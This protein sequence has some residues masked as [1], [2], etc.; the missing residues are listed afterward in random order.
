MSNEFK[1]A[2]WLLNLALEIKNAKSI[3]ITN[4][5]KS[6]GSQD[7]KSLQYQDSQVEII[8]HKKYQ[9]QEEFAQELIIEL[10]R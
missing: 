5:E 10:E 7:S 4:E 2:V 1:A 6:Q 3:S 8:Q 9:L